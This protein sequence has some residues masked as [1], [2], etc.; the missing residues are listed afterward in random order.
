MLHGT[1]LAFGVEARSVENA[2]FDAPDGHFLHLGVAERSYL[3]MP[4]SKA[5]C[6]VLAYV[7]FP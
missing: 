5:Q 7:V 1:L 4:K 3:K 2:I 6:G